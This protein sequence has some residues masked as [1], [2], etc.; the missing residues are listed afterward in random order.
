MLVNP[1]NEREQV[2]GI[3]MDLTRHLRI[4]RPSEAD[5]DDVVQPADTHAPHSNPQPV[6]AHIRPAGDARHGEQQP[7]SA[8]AGLGASGLIPFTGILLALFMLSGCSAFRPLKGIPVCQLPMEL[9]G[10]SRANMETI[11]LL[12]LGQT[13]LPAH[14]IDS[15]DILAIYV[16]GILGKVED[17]P[18]INLPQNTNSNPTVGYPIPVRDDGTISLPLIAPLN[19]RGMTLTQAEA[20]VR[21]AYTADAGQRA[22]GD[23]ILV[24]LHKARS[25]KITVLRQ[26]TANAPL[27]SVASSGSI[28]L[29]KSKLGTGQIVVLQAGEND[30]LHA[31]T[32][33]GGLP[34]LDAQDVLYVI[35][36]PRF[37]PNAAAGNYIGQAAKPF[38]AQLHESEKFLSV[39]PVW[40]RKSPK[41]AIHLARFQGGAYAGRYGS[42][43]GGA[44]AGSFNGSANGVQ[45]GWGHSVPQ[46]DPNEAVSLEGVEPQNDTANVGFRQ[47]YSQPIPLRERMGAMAMPFHQP[48]GPTLD[49]PG[50][51]EESPLN[52]P[53]AMQPYIG[54]GSHVI[55]IPIRL[56]PGEEAQFGEQDIMLFDGDILFIESRQTE[57]FYTGGLLGGGQ[58]QLP[59]DYDLN[60]LAAI[61]V[62]QGGQ[63]QSSGGGFGSRIG[64]I[65]AVNQDISVSASNLV[66][67]RPTPD[68]GR[69]NIKVNLNRVLRDQNENILILPGDHLILRYTPMEAIGAFVERN[70][71]AGSLFGL[72]ASQ[73]TGG[74]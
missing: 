39:L 31:L 36:R 54:Q 74:K 18:P 47:G 5:D 9:R 63:G 4:Y 6:D 2:G 7:S 58:Y 66:I 67:I 38:R 24:S 25:Y 52:Y 14:L 19:V 46:P 21:K 57:I 62:A 34:G 20:L 50:P 27:V 60:V 11:D 35:R 3:N 23:G 72:A 49:V 16:E 43:A 33:T 41:S 53:P 56:H 22:K 30:V 45:Y 40:N 10:T 71:L 69:I 44:P 55:R 29:G 68:G 26:E 17:A 1:T 15:G 8:I 65:S 42:D 73:A 28:Q 12:R 59:R 37:S 32:L 61:A 70:L 48:V 13:P 64:G 51:P